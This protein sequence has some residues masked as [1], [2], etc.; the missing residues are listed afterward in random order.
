[1]PNEQYL[2]PLEVND[3]SGFLDDMMADVG[4]SLTTAGD[5]ALA[6]LQT[7]ITDSITSLL[8]APAPVPVTI[9]AEIL[10]P[11]V[12][13]QQAA[14]AL[15]PAPVVASTGLAVSPLLLMVGIAWLLLSD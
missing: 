8:P 10:A 14:P 6:S 4:D 13:E 12:I 15:A 3:Y 7:S 1:M 5:T 2:N 11:A 9:E